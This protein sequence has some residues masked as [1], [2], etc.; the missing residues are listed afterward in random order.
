[1][2]LLTTLLFENIKYRLDNNDVDETWASYFLTEIAQFYKIMRWC[3]VNGSDPRCTAA[4]YRLCATSCLSLDAVKSALQLVRVRDYHQ[5]EIRFESANAA[6]V[7]PIL[8][9]LPTSELPNSR[10]PYPL[11]CDLLQALFLCRPL[12]GIPSISCLRKI[13][14]A[15]SSST[16]ALRFLAASILSSADHWFQDQEL[17]PILAHDSVW[18]GFGE[19]GIP[20][21]LSLGERLSSRSQWKPILA[22]NLP[23]WLRNYDA[24]AGATFRCV[25]SRIWGVNE[26]EAE[27]YGDAKDLAMVFRLL[28]NAWDDVDISSTEDPKQNLVSLVRTV[29]A[30]IRDYTAFEI[31]S[32]G[33][34]ISQVLQDTVILRLRQAV[35]QAE[36]RVKAK[37]CVLDQESEHAMNFLTT[38]LLRFM[39]II[40]E[41]TSNDRTDESTEFRDWIQRRNDLQADA[42]VLCEELESTSVKH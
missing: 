21:F 26:S 35:A 14:A 27:E 36:E 23:S 31:R 13:L 25:L 10:D 11:L 3:G 32:P 29:S 8:E 17:G 33:P 22:R 19:S 12:T 37:I 9:G 2:A 18:I 15:L 42:I 7:Y 40:T 30:R 1:M 5:T 41:H 38:L 34:E 39:Q 20:G 28:T 6:W 16:E 24:D 4:A